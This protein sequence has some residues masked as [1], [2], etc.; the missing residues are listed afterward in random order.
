MEHLE[1]DKNYMLAATGSVDTGENWEADFE[2]AYKDGR[3][4]EVWCNGGSLIEV[5][6]KQDEITGKP[7]WEEVE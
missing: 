6:Q 1:K 7:F 3:L 2:E 5:E 4:W